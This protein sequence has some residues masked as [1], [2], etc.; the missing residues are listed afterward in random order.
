MPGPADVS[1]AAV[2]GSDGARSDSAERSGREN[3]E[4]RSER[5]RL[6]A[7]EAQLEVLTAAAALN[8]KSVSAYVMQVALARARQDLATAGTTETA[9]NEPLGVRSPGATADVAVP[10]DAK[11]TGHTWA[12]DAADDTRTA[13]AG[14][15][16]AGAAV[17]RS[18]VCGAGGVAVAGGAGGPAE[19]VTALVEAAS[20]GARR[21]AA[22]PEDEPLEAASRAA[23]L[24]ARLARTAA[25]HA[26]DLVR[27]DLMHADAAAR[28][29]VVVHELWRAWGLGALA[30]E[31][32]L[33]A[34]ELVTNAF[35]HGGGDTVTLS[36]GMARDRGE[37]V[38]GVGDSSPAPP[39]S[40]RAADDEEGGRGLAL[41][42]AMASSCGWYRVEGGKV[43]WFSQRASDGP[44][45]ARP[46]RFPAGSCLPHPV[47]AGGAREAP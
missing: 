12:G 34:S 27:R 6:N 3:S 11:A 30:D 40:G 36:L 41:V 37:V 23:A 47:L 42:A 1:G 29:R 8:G 31:G 43:V 21:A 38:C 32:M 33:M 15:N 2:P 39:R 4:E 9:E 16:A 28:A 13:G 24:E 5:W 7:D 22:V 14:P 17:T 46:A 10:D 45:P 20:S 19:P 25:G 26:A 44:G 18:H 35:V